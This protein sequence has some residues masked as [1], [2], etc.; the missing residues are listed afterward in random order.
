MLTRVRRLS[1]TAPGGE[2]LRTSHY[3]IFTT[4]KNR[5]IRTCLPGFMEVAHDHYRELTWLAD[6]QEGKKMPIYMLGTRSE[7]AALTRS[8]V[9]V[10]TELY[11]SIQ[12]GG[13]CYRGVC[14]FWEM[15]GYA[16]FMVAAH[17]GL[18]QFLHHRLRHRLPMWVEEGLC[19]LAEGYK[20]EG[21]AVWF[22]PRKNPSR[23]NS[24]RTAIVQGRW[25]RLARLLSM[26]A[27]DAIGH[28]SEEAVAYYGQVW[29]LVLFIRSTAAYRD[30]FKRMLSD[31]EAGRF[32]EALKLPAEAKPMLR[33]G[34]RTYNRTF[35][36]PLFKHYISEDVAGFEK[37]YRAFA[38]KLTKLD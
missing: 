26:D 7:W 24:L 25:I 12:A 20:I 37:E 21:Q 11:L 6:R 33:R 31:A 22:T 35:S 5:L 29:A 17:E 16:T 19:V 32:N 8:V 1:W 10:N 15:G 3:D 18:H 14:V 30:G 28:G 27:G 4:A 34:G 36:V 38:K 9:K 23:F 2:Q 13:Y